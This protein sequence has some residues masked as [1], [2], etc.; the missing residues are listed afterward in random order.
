[1]S[2]QA[3][4]VNLTETFSIEEVT[5]PSVS[6]GGRESKGGE[7]KGGKEDEEHDYSCSDDD[8]EDYVDE[9]T[10]EEDEDTD[11]DDDEEEDEEWLERLRVL[12]DA[13][14]L[15]KVAEFFLQPEKP[16]E[17][18][19]TC[20][21]RCFFDRPSM[22]GEDKEEEE[23]RA[24]VLED[25]ALLKKYAVHYLHPEIPVTATTDVT[26]FGRNYFHRAASECQ[27]ESI[28][29]AEERALIMNDAL[30]LKKQA[31]HFYHPE[32]PVETDSTFVG[33]NYFTRPS[34]PEQESEGEVEERAMI[35][36][37]ALLLKKQAVHY[38]YPESPVE[39]DAFAM[40][41]NYFTCPSATEQESEGEIEERATILADALLLK[42]QAVHYYHPEA[43]V[44]TDAFVMGR[45][46][47]S[48]SSATEQESEEEAEERANIL[49]DALLLKKQAID[50]YHPEAPVKKDAF[51]MGR[52]YFTRPSS[53][54]QESEEKV[55]ERAMILADALL[56]KKQAIDYYHPEAPVETDAF[57]M[58]RNYFTRPSATEQESEGEV[59]ERATILAD[60]LLLK[61]QAVH[62]YHPEA[63]VETDAFAMGRNYFSRSSATEQ[64]S[65]E[66]AEERAMI[67]ADALLLKKQAANYYHPEAPIETDAFAMGR[68]YF[69]R[70]SATEQESEEEAEE[71]AMILEDA[72][73]LKKQAV[74][75]Y[76]PESPV[77]IDSTFAGRNYF[78]RPSSIQQESE[79]EAEERAMIIADVLLLKKQAIDYY[80][81]EAPV[82]TDSTAMG[83]NYFSRI[84]AVEQ[85]SEEEVDERA[86]ILADALLLKKQATN[87]YHPEAPVETDAFAMGRNYFARPSA[88]EQE[89]EEEVEE[90]SMILA[91]ALLL[92]KQAANYYHP[93]APVEAD[94]FATGRNYFLRSSAT[95]QESEEE[96]EE[97]AMILADA[98][99]LKKQAVHYYH[100]EAPVE[101][102]STFVG[103][104]YFT[105]PS[106]PEQE[107]EVEAE[108][109][110]MI[111]ADAQLLKEQAFD[112]YHPEAP[113]KTD[114][115][116]MG[117]N[118]FTRP[119]AVEQESEEEAEEHTRI[120]ADAAVLKQCA[121][122]YLH[123]E[124]HV[125]TTD[126]FA[127][128][129][130]YFSRLSTA[131]QE[132]KEEAEER[133]RILLDIGLLTKLAV[134]YLHPEVPVKIDSLTM[135]RNYFNRASAVG[136]NEFIHSITVEGEFDDLL[137][138]EAGRCES[139]KDILIT[140]TCKNAV[141]P[142][143]SKTIAKDIS[144]GKTG[145][146]RDWG[147]NGMP[148]S[149]SAVMLFNPNG[150]MSEAF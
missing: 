16:V 114:S 83:R 93:D 60:V 70:S 8:D 68:N 12:E 36:A 122:D 115:T 73:L 63:P 88:V 78:T 34:A 26:I 7:S 65:E 62:Y 66:E 61:K 123:P 21:A 81:P 141:L 77:E 42:K 13:R 72:M 142:S 10:D 31:V 79:E 119:S 146:E 130:N 30:L 57:A 87:Y 58:G 90:R 17:I 24:R 99:L 3:T 74:H 33:R 55:E 148:R 105:R 41:R 9:L 126:A 150:N 37:D 97:R 50:Y 59:E 113:V 82:E 49:E 71:R 137:A 11:D 127:M 106:A 138:P 92:K 46:Y 52:N 100:P 131:V 22:V 96:A 118:Y 14:N 103:R 53:I 64:E 121:V 38:Y 86:T 39:T 144:A 124:V 75:Y 32:S 15:K 110:A 149:A 51:A 117:R 44:E 27:Q 135:G 125:K 104:N 98:L 25:V 69:S 35:L 28:E 45:N 19:S 29:E 108:E 94:A 109:R 6:Q 80:H 139:G 54:Q 23:E 134:D 40:G 136:A 132:S 4:D 47:F 89:S 91:D 5:L 56:L 143:S 48:R 140:N 76:H 116:A 95:E 101:T 67:L 120:L 102:D 128:G 43:P 1:M 111:L 85:E 84:S 133:S 107:S 2:S 18:E 129:S 20:S 147:S 145:P 112:Y